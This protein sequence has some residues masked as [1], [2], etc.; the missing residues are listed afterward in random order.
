[1]PGRD[2]RGRLGRGSNCNKKAKADKS[3]GSRGYGRRGRGFGRG[4]RRP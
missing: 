2:G 1:M 4:R 3:G